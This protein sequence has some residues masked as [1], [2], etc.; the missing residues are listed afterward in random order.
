MGTLSLYCLHAPPPLELR[1]FCEDSG[2]PVEFARMLVMGCVNNCRRAY[3]STADHPTP[4]RQKA[5]LAALQ[6]AVNNLSRVSS[7]ALDL[8]DGFETKIIDE[9]EFVEWNAQQGR[10]RDWV[11]LVIVGTVVRSAFVHFNIPWRTHEDALAVRLLR[12][13]KEAGDLDFDPRR[14]ADRTAKEAAATE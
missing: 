2:M 3:E 12:L 4:T 14:L 1:L 9:M 8:P 6:K 13:I 11:H 10:T 7:E 5:E